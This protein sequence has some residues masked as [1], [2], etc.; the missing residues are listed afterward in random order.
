MTP[1][2]KDVPLEPALAQALTHN[3]WELEQKLE[4]GRPNAMTRAM[5]LRAY[6]QHLDNREE[7]LQIPPEN[8]SRIRVV[9][10]AKKAV[11]L[12]HG[13]TGSPAD[14]AEI[15]DRLYEANCTVHLVRLPGHGDDTADLS[16]SSWRAAVSH[17]ESHYR[18]LSNCFLEPYVLGYSFGGAVA[19]TMTMKPRPKGL[20][21][22]A[23]A[24]YPKLSWLQRLL[25]GVGLDRV[26]LIRRI[27]GWRG[28][29]LDSM[30]AARRQTW[31][32]GIPVHAAMARDD[33]R[34]D[35]QSL[36]FVKHRAKHE[37]SNF[38]TYDSGG[39]GFVRGANSARVA[40]DILKFILHD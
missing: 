19:L 8:R 25:V 2:S 39:H 40:D 23:P 34:I 18:M 27:L 22:L 1:A 13:S 30:E 38:V 15:A 17:A 32:K 5:L 4:E 24:L 3:I 20:V 33:E 37:Q 6:S 35:Q 12:I 7:M 10:G 9:D 26:G 14:L 28:Q 11:L 29:V 36:T 16:Q 31:W 21:L